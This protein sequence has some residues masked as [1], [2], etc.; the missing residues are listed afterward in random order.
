MALHPNQEVAIDAVVHCRGH[1]RDIAG[2]QRYICVAS[3]LSGLG[4]LL[5]SAFC[6]C[7]LHQ[8]DLIVLRAEMAA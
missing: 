8:P 1:V 5:N 6:N 2:F 4:L 7:F 3:E